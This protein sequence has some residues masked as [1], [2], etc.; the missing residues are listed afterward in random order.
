MK[1]IK[2]K[3]RVQELRAQGC[4]YKEINKNLPSDLSKSTLSCWCKGIK[5]DE[6]YRLRIKEIVNKNLSIVRK[7]A[8]AT[9]RIKKEKNLANIYE[10]NI[11]AR[12]ELG[13]N[14]VAR[15]ALAVLYLAEGKKSGS[16]VMLG[17]SDPGI[18]KL[19]LKL[20]DDVHGIDQK[21]IHCTLQCRADQDVEQLQKYWSKVTKIPLS[22]FYKA[23]IDPRTKGKKTLK[24]EYKGVCRIDYLST[25]V[26]NKIMIMGRILTE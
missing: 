8:W 12:D 1:N 15:I 13:K 26:L 9:N 3:K 22:Q 2:L 18:I 19:F 20:L 6:K 10:R 25:D 23:R 4:T 16:S 7:K 5:M 21:K 11:S 24:L 14:V 17:N